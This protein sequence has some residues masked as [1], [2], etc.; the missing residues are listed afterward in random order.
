MDGEGTAT[1]RNTFGAGLMDIIAMEYGEKHISRMGNGYII[2]RKDDREVVIQP[3]RSFATMQCCLTDSEGDIVL[4]P[5]ERIADYIPLLMSALH[6]QPSIFLSTDKKSYVPHT[7]RTS[8]SRIWRTQ[9]GSS[10]P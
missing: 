4:I 1:E 7:G 5:V 3:K 2:V 8:K 6:V 9:G 10:G